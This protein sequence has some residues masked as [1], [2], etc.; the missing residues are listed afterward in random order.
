M[1]CAFQTN[2]QSNP[3]FGA[4]AHIVRKSYYKLT[5]NLADYTVKRATGAMSIEIALSEVAG[6]TFEAMKSAYGDSFAGVCE[7]YRIV[8]H[9]FPNANLAD[10]LKG[11]CKS[12]KL[13]D[14]NGVFNKSPLRVLVIKPGNEHL[15][16][17]S[18]DTFV[19]NGVPGLIDIKAK[20]VRINNV[21]DPELNIYA[22]WDCKVNN[23]KLNFISSDTV[24]ELDNVTADRG[25]LSTDDIIAT[26]VNSPIMT[27]ASGSIYLHGE[28]NCFDSLFSYFSVTSS[29][30]LVAKKVKSVSGDVLLDGKI[31]KIDKVEADG[32]FSYKDL[33]E[34]DNFVNYANAKDIEAINAKGINYSAN[35][36]LSLFGL[37]NTVDNLSTNG[38][39]ELEN[40]TAKNIN[41]YGRSVNILGRTNKVS[42][43]IYAN[44]IVEATNLDANIIECEALIDKGNVKFK[45]LQLFKSNP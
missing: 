24:A 2:K 45:D 38:N 13:I 8:K 10:A 23:S 18:A 32:L 27:S 4:N 22:K 11:L 19:N 7:N 15:G 29:D 42:E 9:N 25:I 28:N 17:V 1:K 31:N 3:S 12:F 40:I 43:K 41:S 35:N 5:D 16:N 44:K 26:N 21:N 33:P 36:S 34:S 6:K 20:N 39:I 30:G 37:K 14:E